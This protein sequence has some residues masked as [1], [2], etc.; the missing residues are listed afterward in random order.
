M[1]RR[2]FKP[3]C[4]FQKEYLTNTGQFPKQELQIPDVKPE[5]QKASILRRRQQWEN[6][7]RQLK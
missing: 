3:R 7:L 2:T 4:N 5:Q 6:V 1:T